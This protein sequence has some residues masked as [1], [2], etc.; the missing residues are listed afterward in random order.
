M[1]NAD[2]SSTSFSSGDRG[3][4]PPRANHRTDRKE[5]RE[6]FYVTL[7]EGGRFF[8]A[9]KGNL[10]LAARPFQASTPTTHSG[11]PAFPLHSGRRAA[12]VVRSSFVQPTAGRCR[13][14]VDRV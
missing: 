7:L 4:V 8:F 2:W 9:R 13:A 10:E 12:V 14:R 3:R 11:C 5:D 1:K 6:E